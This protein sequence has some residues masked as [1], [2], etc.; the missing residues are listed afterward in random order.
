MSWMYGGHT[1]SF[2]TSTLLVSSSGV[3]ELTLSF[4]GTFEDSLNTYTNGPA[5]VIL[6]LNDAG[7]GEATYSATFATPP[8]NVPEPATLAMF[9]SALIGLGLVGRKR[10]ARR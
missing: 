8:P 5:L 10:W 3:G 4:S 6:S 2:D 9:G 7:G 1:Y